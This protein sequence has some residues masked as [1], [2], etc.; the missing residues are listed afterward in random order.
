M[1]RIPL[2][3]LAVGMY[4][5]GLDKSWLETP[6]LRHKMR[7]TGASQIRALRDSGVRFVEIDPGKGPAPAVGG[8]AP[9]LAAPPEAEPS[10]PRSAPPVDAFTEELPLATKAYQEAKHVVQRAMHEVRMGQ[11]IN[12]EAVQKAVD[13][14]VDS[15][16]RNE[17]ALTSLSRLKSYDEYTF[18]HSVNTAVLALALGRSLELDRAALRSLGTG[19]LLHDVGKMKIPIGIL[20]KP[21]KL[22]DFEFAIIKQHA[23]RGA[24]ILARTT[25]LEEE[26]IRPALEHHERVNGSGYPF[27]KTKEQLTQFGLISS[28][29]DVYDAMTSD[30]VYHKA[31]P[32]HH[33]LKFLFNLGQKG[34][35]DPPLVERFIKCLGIYPVGSCVLL[36]TGETAL[37]EQIRQDQPLR[38]RLILV[39]DATGRPLRR[40]RALD[41]AHAAESTR[42]IAAV[43]DP[44]EVGIDPALF[45]SQPEF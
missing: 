44:V 15:V 12:T 19:A 18:F 34:H 25:G 6:F 28:V 35:L 26:A 21:G 10:A 32:P 27:G 42:T 30:R 5:V 24:E 4:I 37:V 14:L 29:V 2:E 8:A 13:G 11:A 43:L 33:A 23:L 38:P 1:A 16:L 17:D 22:K 9:A 41:L 40:G 31:M 45:L 39:R 7:I 36:S 20:N 3:Q